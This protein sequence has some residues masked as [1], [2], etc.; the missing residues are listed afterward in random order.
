[1]V[2][3]N[4]SGIILSNHNTIDKKKMESKA[5]NAGKTRFDFLMSNMGSVH[6]EN[7]LSF[8]AN[9]TK[10]RMNGSLETNR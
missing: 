9:F 8:W 10:Y 4:T 3:V 1:M 2:G 5:E 7:L 6:Q